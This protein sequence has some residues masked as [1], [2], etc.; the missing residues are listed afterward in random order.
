MTKHYHPTKTEQLRLGDIA[1]VHRGIST[2]ANNY[3]VLNDAMVK[4]IG[5]S[6]EYL[7]KTIP[8][9][10]PRKMLKSSFTIDDW[11]RFCREGMPC[12][13]FYVK[14]NIP[15][16][17]LTS[18]VRQYIRKGEREGVNLVPT[19]KARKEWYS[20]K[21]RDEIPDLV[22]T[23]MFRDKP[24]FLYNEAKAL[25]L[26]NFIGIYLKRSIK[27]QINDMLIFAIMLNQEISKYLSHRNMGR[28]YAGGLTNLG[29]RDLS[30][31]PISN[32]LVS[33]LNQI[34]L[35]SKS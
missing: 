24:L 17:K 26:T 6:K 21:L 15:P 5:I 35:L 20:I 4:E 22:F 23:Y 18:E 30:N 29:P 7:K 31:T 25:N 10:I 27:K 19:C 3:F 16:E 13:L 34:S 14:P 12:W 32:S 9:K 28:K 33:L 1:E 8:P 2:G 11:E